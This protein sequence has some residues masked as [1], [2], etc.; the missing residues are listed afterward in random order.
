MDSCRIKKGLLLGFTFSFL[1]LSAQRITNFSLYGVGKSV[2][3]NFT[4]VKGSTCNGY[5]VYHS[6]DS[7]YFNVIE[8]YSG[9]CGDTF[10][11]VNNSYT[12]QN[13]TPNAFNYYKVQIALGEVSETKSIY[14]SPGANSGLILYPN[15]VSEVDESIN[16]R[17]LASP[18]SRLV[19]DIY[20]CTGK[21]YGEL[22]VRT[23][24]SKA[25][26]SITGLKSGIYFVWLT[27]G[28]LVYSN[29]FIVL[30]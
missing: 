12:H 27:D 25:S 18:N 11:D 23:M 24:D 16:F 30:R 7:M 26:F 13:P 5:T 20:D 21:K 19:G 2:G 22:D 14:V 4:V 9:I 29:K 8:D 15:P 1:H 3:L 17:A 6:L 10:E 28:Q